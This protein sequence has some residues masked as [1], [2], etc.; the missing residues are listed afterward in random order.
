MISDLLSI[1]I[2]CIKQA[3]FV[4]VVVLCFVVF[5][6]YRVMKIESK[7]EVAVLLAV[8]F[9]PFSVG[10]S[11]SGCSVFVFTVEAPFLSAHVQLLSVEALLLTARRAI[12]AWK[13]LNSTKLPKSLRI[14]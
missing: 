9:G 7:S 11:Y 1:A 10:L 8:S 6:E 5:Q 2:T 14:S 4:T 12:T 3:F 13:S